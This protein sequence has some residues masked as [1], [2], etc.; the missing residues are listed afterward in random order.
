MSVVMTDNEVAA[1]NAI[2]RAFA[3][4]VVAEDGVPE[5]DGSSGMFKQATTIAS[6]YGIYPPDTFAEDVLRE[7]MLVYLGAAWGVGPYAPWYV[8]LIDKIRGW[9]GR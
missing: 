5:S 1:K 2:V 7:A 8:K 9:F 3:D 6:S 4:R